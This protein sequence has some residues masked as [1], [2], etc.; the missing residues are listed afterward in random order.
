MQDLFRREI[1]ATKTYMDLWGNNVEIRTGST[2]TEYCV[3]RVR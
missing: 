2:S 1:G 3:L